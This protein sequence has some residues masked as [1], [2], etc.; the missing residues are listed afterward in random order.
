VTSH[1]SMVPYSLGADQGKALPHIGR[2]IA[3]ATQTNGSFE[4]I[5]TRHGF[6]IRP[7]ARGAPVHLAGGIGGILHRS[8]KNT[9]D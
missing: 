6:T 2:L 1:P 7:G 4:I 9:D 8:E 3:T 5:V